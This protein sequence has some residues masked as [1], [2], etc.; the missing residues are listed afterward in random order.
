MPIDQAIRED[1][2]DVGFDDEAGVSTAAE[3][4]LK[5]WGSD[6]EGPSD[7]DDEEK[8]SDAREDGERDA[9]N[10]D[11]TDDEE[12]SEEE[13]PEEETDEDDHKAKSKE[14]RRVAEDD[15]EVVVKVG[16]Q[17][18][19][20]SVRDVKR[21]LGQ[22][23]SLTKKS[24]EVSEKL[25]AVEA[26]EREHVEALDA[27]VKR[28][29]ERAKPYA[30]IDW[31]VVSKTL[32]AEDLKQLREDAKEAFAD[33]NYLTQERQ[34]LAEA[35]QQR[36]AEELPKKVEA[37]IKAITD[38]TSPSHIPGW[39]EKVYSEIRDFAI[40]RLKLPAEDVNNETNPAVIKM[41]WMASQF[42]KAQEAVKKAKPV[43]KASAKK[44]L[45]PSTPSRDRGDDGKFTSSLAR[46][47]RSGRAEDAAA[48]LLEAWGSRD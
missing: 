4:L 8:G 22:E 1:A 41:L 11:E 10:E 29:H 3:M 20:A 46:A 7:G 42:A 21:L 12:R 18:L 34:K 19:R 40:E 38:E 2:E 26:K 39:S 25:K 32:S 47:K 36:Q 15:D 5:H 14:A 27:M 17:E 16:D 13:D 31:L 6:A 23:A 9:D 48:A 45:K 37:A 28:A 35:A 24:M 30:E 44:V 43:A 33:Y